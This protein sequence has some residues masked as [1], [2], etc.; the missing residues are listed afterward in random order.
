M[1]ELRIKIDMSNDAFTDVEGGDHD[2]HIAGHEVARMLRHLAE[3]FE[4]DG[5]HTG[6]RKRLTDRNGGNRCG[7]VEVVR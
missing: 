1:A 5:I 2:P 4:K 7:E 6:F 3:G